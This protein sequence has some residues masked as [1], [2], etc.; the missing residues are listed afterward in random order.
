MVKFKFVFVFEFN[1]KMP[2]QVAKQLVI[3]V[4]REKPTITCPFKC[5][6]G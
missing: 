2:P 1:N 4:N 3:I 5:P 6:Y